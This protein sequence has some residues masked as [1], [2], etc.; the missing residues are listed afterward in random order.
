LI[1]RGIAE[2]TRLGKKM[3]A[4]P[5]TFA[6]LAGIGDLVLTCTGKL[7]RNRYVGHEI[8]KGKSL[9]EVLSGMRMVA[10]GVTT[11]QSVRNLAQKMSIEM[12][13]CEQVYQV[14][15][16][17]KEPRRA[18]QDLMTRELKEEKMF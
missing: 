12:P 10:E 4:N 16:Q 18:L 6:G 2:I 3:G 17:E 1:T 8:G 11:T 14:L 7:S 5:G 15:Y 13:I 9:E